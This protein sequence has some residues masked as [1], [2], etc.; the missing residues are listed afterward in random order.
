MIQVGSRQIWDASLKTN[1]PCTEMGCT[2]G[3]I[4]RDHIGSV[5]RAANI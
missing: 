1:A 2:V 4:T 3:I 5:V